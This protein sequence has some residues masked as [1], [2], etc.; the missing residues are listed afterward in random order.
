MIL[1]DPITPSKILSDN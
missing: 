1:K